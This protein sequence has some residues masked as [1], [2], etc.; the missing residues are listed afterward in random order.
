MVE[1]IFKSPKNVRY[2]GLLRC[3]C[4][5]VVA[6]KSRPV[7]WIT[8][9]KSLRLRYESSPLCLVSKI[10]QKKA[11]HHVSYSRGFINRQHYASLN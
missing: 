9:A 10:L 7:G 2:V 11:C 8:E 4:L 6:Y 3:L 5:K 1:K